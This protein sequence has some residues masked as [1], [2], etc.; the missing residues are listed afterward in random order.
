MSESKHTPGPWKHHQ[1]AHPRRDGLMGFAIMSEEATVADMFP[2]T[3]LVH[4]SESNARLISAAPDLLEACR[5]ANAALQHFGIMGD[6]AL[7]KVQAAIAKATGE[8]V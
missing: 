3:Y 4:V 5:E 8:Q 6:P 2:E 7:F 1:A